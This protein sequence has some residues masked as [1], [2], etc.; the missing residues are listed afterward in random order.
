MIEKNAKIFIAGHR[1]M[2]GSAIMRKFE[3]EGYTNLITRTRQELDL[4]HQD[5]VG[6][7]YAEEKLEYVIAASAKVGGIKANME[8]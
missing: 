7:F 2:V 6:K 4:C 5:A 3:V 8:R 1:G